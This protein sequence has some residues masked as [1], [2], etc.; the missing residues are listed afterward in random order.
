MCRYEYAHNNE[1]L[2]LRSIFLM[3]HKKRIEHRN[4]TTLEMPPF[5]F[6]F[7]CSYSKR[8]C[9][10]DIQFYIDLDILT[11]HTLSE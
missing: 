7:A 4:I 1:K 9:T 10:T 8:Y 3:K 11:T 5:L 6:L 2:L